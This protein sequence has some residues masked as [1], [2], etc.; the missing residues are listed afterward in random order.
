MRN[1]YILKCKNYIKIAHIRLIV[2]VAGGCE[3]KLL[4]IPHIKM[5]PNGDNRSDATG[6][7]GA[8]CTRVFVRYRRA[9]KA[10]ATRRLDDVTIP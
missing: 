2:V 10:L 6:P 8:L 5:R 3:N 9:E 1:L 7:R 4:Q